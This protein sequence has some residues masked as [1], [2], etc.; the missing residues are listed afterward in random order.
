MKNIAIVV[1]TYNRK[2]SLERLIESL[3]KSYYIN[4]NVDL[5]I[6]ID[7][8]DVFTEMYDYAEKL[9]WK[10]G[11][12]I[13]R[14]FPNRLGLKKH[15]MECGKLLNSY[16][17]IIVLEDDLYVSPNFYQYSKL[18][19][20]KYKDNLEIAGISLYNYPRNQYAN[21]PFYPLIDQYDV[22]FMRIASSWG[23]VWSRGGWKLFLKWLDKNIDI[24][25]LNIPTHIKKW[26]DKSW[27][28]YHHAYCAS[29][30]KYFVYPRVALSTNFSEP[31]EHASHDSTFQVEILQD[32]KSFYNLPDNIISA[33]RYDE[34]FENENAIEIFE[35]SD[36]YTL[37][38]YCKKYIRN[39]YLITTNVLNYKIIKSYGMRMRPWETNVINDIK[40]DDIFVY[41]M[42]YYDSKIYIL[43]NNSIISKKYKYLFKVNSLREISYIYICL[44]KEKLNKKLFK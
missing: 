36:N 29:E 4:D 38:L 19:I 41:D 18:M 30:N 15:V 13:I 14:T 39:R 35:G 31:G 11:E 22:Y 27:L 40:G 34:F 23:Q 28:K 26:D 25:E 2:I 24:E 10:Y 6:S 8:S 17:N 37:D 44:I 33:I 3:N 20:D 21:L 7:R 9:K 12:K 32:L 16:E 5:I 43:R 1:I 42:N